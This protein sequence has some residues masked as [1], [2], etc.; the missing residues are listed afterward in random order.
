MQLILKCQVMNAEHKT[1][2]RN[3]LGVLVTELEAKNQS[4]VQ[5]P[6]ASKFPSR[7]LE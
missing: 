7:T 2:F 1:V 5:I 6:Q 3:S 4:S